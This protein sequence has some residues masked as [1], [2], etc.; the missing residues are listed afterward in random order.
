MAAAAG[1]PIAGD[2]DVG[3]CYYSCAACISLYAPNMVDLPLLTIADDQFDRA[4]VATFLF[5]YA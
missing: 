1:Q 4:S 2:T 5:V 3:E